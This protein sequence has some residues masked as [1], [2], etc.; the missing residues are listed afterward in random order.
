M[1][2][3]YQ[4]CVVTKQQ[5]AITPKL[6]LRIAAG[7]VLFFVLGHSVGHFTRKQVSDPQGRHVLKIME[8]Y[9]F[10]QFGQLRSYDENYTGMSLNLLLSLL[11]LTSIILITVPI[12]E[13]S[14]RVAKRLLL[15]VMLC[16]LGFSVTGF[17]FFFP[18]PA[19]TCLIAACLI[20]VSLIKLN[21]IP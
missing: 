3:S 13:S 12:T 2:P 6:L 20:G 5:H 1:K 7:F 21:K 16:L 9:K 14:P 4:F 10:D 11:L 15:P 19:I 8:D 18:V 17:L